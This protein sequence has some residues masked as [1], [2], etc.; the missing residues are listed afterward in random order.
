MFIAV[1]GAQLMALDTII[2]THNNVQRLDVL[3]WFGHQTTKRLSGKMPMINPCSTERE[4]GSDLGSQ[5]QDQHP[6]QTR[7]QLIRRQ[8][9]ISIIAD[10]HPVAQHDPL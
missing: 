1:L 9:Q 5:T 3:L 2:R 10:D 8:Q 6:D 7:K 4:Q